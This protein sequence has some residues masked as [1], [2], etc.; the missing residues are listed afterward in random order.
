MLTQIWAL[1]M[2][3]S[4]DYNG[5]IVSRMFSG[6]FGGVVGVIG[7]RILV[8]LFFLHE[9]GR[10]FSAFHMALNFGIISGPTFSALFSATNDWPNEYWW[11]VGLLALSAVLVFAV[12]E[13]TGWRRE[14]GAVN[15][16]QPEGFVARKKATYLTPGK[17]VPPTTAAETASRSRGT[18]EYSFFLTCA[19]R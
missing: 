16:L 14:P 15:V 6:L 19:I 10:V 8:D 18:Q 5:Y 3:H 7:P 17:V 11:S 1:K 4:G 9:R 12:V 2:T 13:E